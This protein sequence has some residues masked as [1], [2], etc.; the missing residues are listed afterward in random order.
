M[1]ARTEQARALGVALSYKAHGGKTR[2]VPAK[3]VDRLIA[4][5]QPPP[6]PQPPEPDMAAFLPEDIAG[7]GRVWGISL[8]LYA[9]RSQRNWG[10]GDFTDLAAVMR[11]AAGL[12]ARYVGVNPLHAPFLAEPWRCSPYDPCSR[13]ALNPLYIDP[14]AVADAPA[15]LRA[16]AADTIAAARAAD[17]VDYA[18]VAAAK[19]PAFET[20]YRRFLKA[21]EPAR[22][23]AFERFC[24]DG[25]TDLARH[26]AF[27]ALHARFA[28]DGITGG[29]PAW[30]PAFRRPDSPEVQA[31]VRQNSEQLGF[32]AYLQWIARQ[33]L[34]GAVAAGQAIDPPCDLYLD[35]AVGSS[36][37]ASEMWAGQAHMANGVR[38]GAPPD[39]LSATGQDWGL[40][41]IHPGRLAAAGFDPFRRILR[42]S[43]APAGALRIDHV[44]GF[45]RQFWI[46]EGLPATQ[47]G[48]VAFPQADMISVTAQESR[49]DRCLVVGVDL[50]TVPEGLTEALHAAHILSYQVAPWARGAEGALLAP[51]DFPPLCLAVPHTH[52]MPPLLGF[53]KGGDIEARARLKLYPDAGAAVA[54]RRQRAAEAD[55][56]LA[57][58]GVEQG[59]APEA[60]VTAALRFLAR[61]RAAV[62][63]AALEDLLL[64]EAQMNLPG[65]VDEHPNW[66]RRYA[67]DVEDWTADDTIA[68]RARA[69]RR[70]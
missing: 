30:P 3:T 40:P 10:I 35:L 41:P 15:D 58:W 12:G 48:Y 8:Q 26:T 68:A 39:A 11:W 70:T 25:G 13:L 54:A 61:S 27:E 22:R 28:A 62:I 37:D 45:N 19:R 20:L 63:L 57:A 33:Q 23:Q 18:R 55:E 66:R 16:Q 1:S 34:D 67:R 65:T 44:L 47:G 59:A 64:Q 38:L 6:P 7:G 56:L 4:V 51:E 17:R 5:L 53:L 60:I 49:R 42:A 50:G 46:P 24:A 21:A 14:E 29:F 52:D 2:R 36:A 9:L 32:F 69:A 43:M 31:F